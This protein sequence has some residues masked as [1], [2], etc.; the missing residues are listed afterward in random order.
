MK[1]EKQMTEQ[2]FI[3]K[4]KKNGFELYKTSEIKKM[5]DALIK[6]SVIATLSVNPPQ[7]L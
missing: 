2:Q 1:K 4:F 7:T 6:I 5:S 3:A